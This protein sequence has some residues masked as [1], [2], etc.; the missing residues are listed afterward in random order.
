MAGLRSVNGKAAAKYVSAAGTAAP[1][2]RKILQQKELRDD[3]RQI[4]RS[5]RDIYGHLDQSTARKVRHLLR[6][7]AVHE[8][9]D[10]AAATIHAIADDVGAPRRRSKWARRSLVAGAAGGTVYL[11]ASARGRK[12]RELAMKPF[13]R[14]GESQSEAA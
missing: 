6:E 10:K 3:V 11:L 9:V 5:A 7:A 1:V 12:A 14:E 4:V 2:V 8:N 13:R